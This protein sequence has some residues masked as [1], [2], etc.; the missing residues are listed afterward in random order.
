M[1]G[2]AMHPSMLSLPSRRGALP[3]RGPGYTPPPQ[4]GADVA[5]WQQAPVLPLQVAA[6]ASW[7]RSHGWALGPGVAHGD[8]VQRQGG[9]VGPHVGSR[10][11]DV[12]PR[13]RLARQ[14]EL[15]PG[16][17]RILGGCTNGSGMFVGADAFSTATEAERCRATRAWCQAE[18][19]R[20]ERVPQAVPQ[21]SALEVVGASWT[22]CSTGP[23]PRAPA[24]CLCQHGPAAGPRAPL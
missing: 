10:C 14:H 3:G 11:R 2:P 23:A 6:A 1:R 13:V 7:P 15:V 22:P 19:S 24:C 5:I 21:C 8:A 18:L 20:A 4:A 16:Q 9:R 12:M 17:R